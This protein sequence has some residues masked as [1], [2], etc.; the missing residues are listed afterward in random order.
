VSINLGSLQ[1][2]KHKCELYNTTEKKQFTK[3]GNKPAAFP[4]P[5]IEEISA[6]VAIEKL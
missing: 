6:E 5:A 2:G 3:F 4:Y 1:R